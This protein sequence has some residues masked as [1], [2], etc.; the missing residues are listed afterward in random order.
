MLKEI[1]RMTI[2]LNGEEVYMVK[3]M[4]NELREKGHDLYI[5]HIEIET[6]MKEGA[7]HDR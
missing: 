5:G 4:V 2:I 3:R 6:V 7:E 1:A